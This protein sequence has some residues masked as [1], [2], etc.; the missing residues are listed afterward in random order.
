[1][2]TT[3]LQD[4][5]LALTIF[6]GLLTCYILYNI[7][8]ENKNKTQLTTATQAQAN[9]DNTDSYLVDEK[10]FEIDAEILH[11][12]NHGF[13][14]I[15]VHISPSMQNDVVSVIRALGYRIGKIDANRDI[16]TISWGE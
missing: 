14:Y 10:L 2:F 1:M 16:F 9:M 13:S 4:M 11:A 8:K 7:Y 5:L 15:N 6:L 3:L 12:S